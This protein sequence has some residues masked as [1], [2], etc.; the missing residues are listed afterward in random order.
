MSIR[1][2][3]TKN[4][5]LPPIKIFYTLAAVGTLMFIAVAVA[6]PARA[7]Q[8]YLLNF[9]FFSAIAQGAVLFSALMHTV[10]ARW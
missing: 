1:P 5:P 10:K 6:S 4:K 2:S 7:W 3:K 9:L 8:A